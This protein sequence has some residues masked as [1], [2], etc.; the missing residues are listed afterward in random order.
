MYNRNE[1]C[2]LKTSVLLVG[3]CCSWHF[4]DSWDDVFFPLCQSLVLSWSTPD[5]NSQRQERDGSAS[6]DEGSVEFESKIVEINIH[7]Y[8]LLIYA[9]IFCGW[10]LKP[11]I[12]IPLD[13][14]AFSYSN[15]F[16][17]KIRMSEGNDGG[18][19]FRGIP[20]PCLWLSSDYPPE[21]IEPHHV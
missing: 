3:V 4:P 5:A 18:I 15:D 11:M 10:V 8:D 6:P 13:W 2:F 19:P 16:N 20:V 14:R 17:L 9:R 21:S 7:S 1:P 12:M